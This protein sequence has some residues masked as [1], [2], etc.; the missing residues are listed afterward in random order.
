MYKRKSFEHENELR[1]I[2]MC[3]ENISGKLVSTD[4]DILIQSIRLAPNNQKWYYELVKKTIKR[5]GLDKK[6]INSAL[7]QTPLY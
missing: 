4:L 1:A 2:I 5:Y 3:G 6:V 7:D